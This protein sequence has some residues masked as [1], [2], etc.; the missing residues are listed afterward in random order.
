MEVF[1]TSRYV[2]VYADIPE[3]LDG[4]AGKENIFFHSNELQ[5]AYTIK[6]NIVRHCFYAGRYCTKHIFSLQQSC[7]VSFTSIEVISR[8]S[9]G[10][11]VSPFLSVN[12]RTIDCNIS[13][14][15]SDTAVFVMLSK[16]NSI[17]A[18]CDIVPSGSITEKVVKHLFN[19][20]EQSLCK[21]DFSNADK[22][23]SVKEAAYKSGN[24]GQA[25]SPKHWN[26][27]QNGSDCWTC[28]PLIAES[29]T[30]FLVQ[31]FLHKNHVVAVTVKAVKN[32]S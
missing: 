3:I 27:K 9:L 32:F 2:A 21:Q 15:H 1:D 13:I 19:M 28:S 8:N 22:I 25:F 7:P 23:W 16:E 18:G 17:R 5:Y 24:A 30:A 29:D 26:V 10:K 11:G 6:N 12:S 4:I 20:E 31:T 14:S